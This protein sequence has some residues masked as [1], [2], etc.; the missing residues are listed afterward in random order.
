MGRK[1]V[2]EMFSIMKNRQQIKEAFEMAADSVRAE[3]EVVDEGLVSGELHSNACFLMLEKI[4][5]GVIYPYTYWSAKEIRG[6]CEGGKWD[7]KYNK[8]Y[9][10]AFWSTKH[11]LALCAK[12]NLEIKFGS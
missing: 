7:F 2:S 3:Y 8:E 4:Y 1:A 6:L 9:D 10:W 12:Y 11:F 5:D